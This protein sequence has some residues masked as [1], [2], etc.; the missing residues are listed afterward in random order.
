M[1]LN[2]FPA[3]LLAAIFRNLSALELAAELQKL[4]VPRERTDSLRGSLTEA[5]R[6][7]PTRVQNDLLVRLGV[8]D[9]H[10]RADPVPI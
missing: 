9:S 7:S 1:F 4:E 5:D 3:F 6:M 10:A 2:R 8:F